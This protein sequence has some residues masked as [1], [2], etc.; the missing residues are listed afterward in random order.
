[1][2]TLAY[3]I[4][5]LLLGVTASEAI[6]QPTPQDQE[7]SRT[8]RARQIP[9]FDS[10]EIG[11]GWVMTWHDEFNGKDFNK[12]VWS[13]CTRGKPDWCNTMSSDPSLFAVRKGN[14]I[15]RGINNPD[16]STDPSPY[17]TGGVWTK[18]LVSFAPGG[19]IEIRAKLQGAQGAW[20]A[21]WMLPSDTTMIWP[22]GGEVDICERL[23]FDSYCYQTVHSPYTVNL[24]RVGHPKSSHTAPIDPKGYNT[25]GVQI[26][27]E[28]VIFYINGLKTS[29]YPMLNGGELD[30]FPYFR[31][32]YLLID[33]QLGGNWVGKVN[34][35]DLPVEMAVDYV[36][37]YEYN[38]K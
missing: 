3:A 31:P 20:P 25:Y 34:P 2:K 16:T 28:K 36:R 33:M 9:V 12:K 27:P 15:L 11:N 32:M 10:R 6:A 22:D 7:K 18:G 5:M 30:Q 4:G 35:E 21:I 26:L 8:E 29:E 23:N 37:Y 24:G 1:M 14:L 13:K 19:Y 17:L 38:P